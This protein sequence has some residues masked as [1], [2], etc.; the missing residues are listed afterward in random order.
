MCSVRCW[1]SSTTGVAGT[2]V[3]SD[4]FPHFGPINVSQNQWN[5]FFPSGVSSG[6]GVKVLWEDVELKGV[7]G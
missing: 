3:L 6:G 7:G 5:G 2:N 4:I 1:L